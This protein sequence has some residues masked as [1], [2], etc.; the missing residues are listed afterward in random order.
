MQRPIAF[1]I[2][3]SVLLAGAAFSQTITA[4]T[5]ATTAGRISGSATFGIA[6]GMPIPSVAGAPYSGEQTQEQVQT[7]FDGTHITRS[8]GSMKQ[9]RDSQ[10][11]TRTERA[12]FMAPDAPESPIIVEI[13]DPV[14][15]FRYTLDTQNK[16]THRMAA[17]AAGALPRGFAVGGGSGGGTGANAAQTAGVLGAL[18]TSKP[19]LPGA[20]GAT[21]PNQ[22]V[23]PQMA[24]ENLGTQV[25]EG[26][27]VE[28]HRQT[29]TFPVG[30]QGNDRPIV[31][32][33]EQWMSPD[34]KIMIV[35]KTSD[36]RSGEHTTK[37]INLN[38]S[39]PDPAL[40]QPPPDYTMTDETGPFTIQFSR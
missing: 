22:P 25:I 39:E 4:T 34:L 31:V 24:S 2:G 12:M 6:S 1:S 9:Y 17:P 35:N 5:S 26:V 23:R 27:L 20:N 15:G 18:L 11:R 32:T 36:P 40:F 3:L 29:T 7:L 38:R 28:G 8:M 37:M 33:S 19:P 21:S 30:S 10:G 13:N 14:A 16:V